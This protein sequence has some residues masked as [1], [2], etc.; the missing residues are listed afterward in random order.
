MFRATKCDK[1]FLKGSDML[2]DEI[3]GMQD[4]RAANAGDVIG[5]GVIGWD[6]GDAN[7]MN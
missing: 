3:S 2:A 6:C 5:T 7:A 1:T 4:G